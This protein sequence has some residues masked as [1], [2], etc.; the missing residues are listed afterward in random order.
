MDNPFKAGDLAL[1]DLNKMPGM[2]RRRKR[3]E[4]FVWWIHEVAADRV[5]CSTL[6]GQSPGEW[7]NAA[8]LTKLSPEGQK[9][10]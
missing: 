10:D 6:P 5:K 3:Y 1:L 4:C 8:Y 7:L 9:G 2:P